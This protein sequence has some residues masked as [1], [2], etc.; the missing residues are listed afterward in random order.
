M[1]TVMITTAAINPA[2][3]EI[4]NNIDDNCNGLTDDGL[5][6]L[7]YFTDADNDGF[8]AGAATSSCT[9]IPGAVL[10][11][12][13]CDDN[14][15]AV[16][17]GATELCNGIDDDC[18]GLTDDNVFVP[19]G[20]ISGPA[21][22]CVP[23][24]FSFATFSIAAPAGANFYNWTVPSG[25]SIYAGQGTNSVLGYMVRTIRTQWNQRTNDSYGRYSMRWYRS[26]Y[27]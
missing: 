12:G 21:Q 27:C 5:V 6:F 2:A 4:C 26:G 13:D 25:M 19:L 11:E 7:D 17:P 3:A 18:D 16:H 22:Q 8:G 10:S 20:S 1:V 9:P 23:A 15:N 24:T 14:N